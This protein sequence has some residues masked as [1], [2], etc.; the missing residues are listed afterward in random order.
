MA[1]PA[2]H[3]Q[4]FL[5]LGRQLGLLNDSSVDEC[6]RLC[7]SS[8]LSAEDVVEQ[9]GILD[10]SEVAEVAHELARAAT[11]HR[12]AAQE[13]AAIDTQV[14]SDDFSDDPGPGGHP[15]AQQPS[16]KDTLIISDD[17]SPDQPPASDWGLS[18]DPEAMPAKL[19]RYEI[20]GLLGRGGMGSVYEA[21][22]STLKRAVAIKVLTQTSELSSEDIERFQREARSVA[23]LGTHP[24]IVSVHDFS[25]D[26]GTHYLVMDLV[27]GGSLESW[28]EVA[29]RSPREIA[30]VGWAVAG[31]VGHAHE[32]GVVHRDL[33]PQNVLM[34]REEQPRVTDFGLAREL[35]ESKRL[36]LSGQLLGTPAFMAPEQA[37]ADREDV[38]P[39]TDVFALG[40]ILYEALTNHHPFQQQTIQGT[41]IAILQID[42][43][44]PR[45]LN[46][47]I[48]HDLET[49]VLHCL[50]KQIGNRYADGK[51]LAADLER[52][53]MGEAITAR[54][55]NRW[56]R[57]GRWYRR[58]RHWA[59]PAFTLTAL[60]TV[61][62]VGAWV[63]SVLT[64]RHR[65]VEKL[66]VAKV[67]LTATKDKL[68]KGHRAFILAQASN[69]EALIRSGIAYLS[70]AERV[71]LLA[72]KDL[73]V[74]NQAL[75]VAYITADAASESEQ[76]D[77][78]EF[79]L[80]AARRTEV[81]LERTQIKHDELTQQRQAAKDRHLDAVENV[82]DQA[83]KGK[84]PPGE[85]AYRHAI[86]ELVR[87]GTP[88]TVPLLTE[89][90]NDLTT[91]LNSVTR[92]NFLRANEIRKREQQARLEPI[93]KL[94]EAVTALIGLQPGDTLSRQQEQALRAAGERL[95][96]RNSRRSRPQTRAK[97]LSP[98]LLI[99]RRQQSNTPEHH[100]RLAE[101]IVEALSAIGLREAAQPAL[102]RHL[103]AQ[104]DQRTAA[105][106]AMHLSRLSGQAAN[107]AVQTALQR[108]GW[109]GLFANRLAGVLGAALP[110][111]GPETSSSDILLY[112]RLKRLAGEAEASREASLLLMGRPDAP[113]AAKATL[114]GTLI[115]QGD[116]KQADQIL[117]EAL[118]GTLED[119]D[120]ADLLLE[121]SQLKLSQ[122][123]T[124]LHVH[125]GARDSN[126][127]AEME[128]LS[129]ESLNAL[130][131]AME[132]APARGDL[133]LQRGKVRHLLGHEAKETMADFTKATEVEPDLPEAWLALGSVQQQSQSLYTAAIF[134]FS[135]A[136]ELE[137][138][139]G[140]AWLQRSR[141]LWKRSDSNG[142]LADA[143]RAVEFMPGSI[144]ARLMRARVLRQLDYLIRAEGDAT[145]AIDQDDQ[146]ASAYELRGQIRMDIGQ[147]K[148][149]E[150][151][152][153]KAGR[154]SS[155]APQTEVA[156]ALHR[157][158]IS[159]ARGKSGDFKGALD[160]CNEAL[161]L[162]P[163]YAEAFSWRSL[164][165][166]A[167]NQ[168]NKAVADITR[169]LEIKPLSGV[170]HVNAAN[171]MMRKKGMRQQ[172]LSHADRAIELSPD[173]PMAWCR[174]AQIHARAGRLRR[175]RKDVNQAMSLS[176]RRHEIWFTRG[177]IDF[178]D[179]APEKAIVSFN[180]AI[181][182][183]PRDVYS[184]LHRGLASE[185]IGK[186]E[187]ARKDFEQVLEMAPAES[188]SA[189]EAKKRLEALGD[190]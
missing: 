75:Q 73:K 122:L 2:G 29:P 24:N 171:I 112:A 23:Q 33:K 146:N 61:A 162:L 116:L 135:Q 7:S 15:A 78:A 94:E 121:L 68:L 83:S 89:A 14:I 127:T 180:R 26:R 17:L 45:Q 25:S 63:S 128:A 168:L 137:P 8:D 39:A 188:P 183:M 32:F 113:P 49:I 139:M 22:D 74:R 31:A 141:L 99:A 30:Q 98:R 160:A 179:H 158:A 91:A 52:F 111:P 177:L 4:D 71:M 185:Q 161:E 37:G 80:E 170:Y 120:R 77:L 119:A 6:L 41:L 55:L 3:N 11:I 46:P 130:S 76:W 159:K 147:P 20:R 176:G 109:H 172:A 19:G 56:E 175:A 59:L 104:W 90:L 100:A 101:L 138:T 88:E 87:H 136:I 1:D 102:E 51:L 143:E 34:D 54:P 154:L 149:A 184:L 125:S 36:T 178:L 86:Y 108:F 53:L 79:V 35:E 150:A 10:A 64:D 66:K 42:P 166:L 187:D 129:E 70:Q 81:S 96:E 126:T 44:P 16:A 157:L 84:L 40:I 60:V 153:E 163:S 148:L 132:C 117:F 167:A 118:A 145:W 110:E 27:R 165:W 18:S 173:L 58:Q 9:L 85:V 134:S 21:Y 48:P 43:M 186:L 181:Q 67:E 69:P 156:Q 92:N 12:P 82:L 151:D 97:P 142:A 115:L 133:L 50:R 124:L 114:A 182:Q 93:P 47:R 164:I 107:K 174:R 123:Q 106:T 57:L 62:L 5:N 65:Y 152:L 72:P 131:E 28:L 95:C 13:P 140:L 155:G 105:R 144:P 189:I 190:K 169:A 103:L 38:A